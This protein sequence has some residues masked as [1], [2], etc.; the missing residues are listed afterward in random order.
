MQAGE[1][2]QRI[3]FRRKTLTSDGL[4]GSELV[5]ADYASA[6]ARVKPLSGRERQQSQRPEGV[7]AYEIVV[8]NRDDILDDDVIRWRG[9]DMNIRFI[10]EKGPRDSWLY[11][12][13]EMGA[14]I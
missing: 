7:K 2:D 11:I 13:A 5:F 8:R 9:R 14:P 12:E 3:A 1:L 10:R 6:W 4:G